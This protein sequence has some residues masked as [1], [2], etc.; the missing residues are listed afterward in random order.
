MASVVPVGKIVYLCD[1]VLEDQTTGKT[2]ILGIFNA[3]R[4]PGTVAFPYRLGRV[5]VFAQFSG[6]GGQVPV[7]VDVV[8]GKTDEVVFRSR[9]MLI[10]FSGKQSEVSVCLR[11]RSMKFPVPGVYVVE[12]YCGGRFIDDRLLRLLA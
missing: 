3:V 6:G 2:H 5:C 10:D 1:D 4:T 9:R 7:R 11:I 8:N 12:M